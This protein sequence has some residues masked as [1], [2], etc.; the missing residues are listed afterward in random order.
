MKIKIR[1]AKTRRQILAARDLVRMVYKKCFGLDLNLLKGT[2]KQHFKKEVLIATCPLTN[3]ILGTLSFMYPN[4]GVFPCESFFGYDLADT[5]KDKENYI[6]IGR[7]ATNDESKK[8]LIVVISLFLGMAQFLEER[9]L[10]GWIAVIKDHIYDFFTRIELP[11]NAINQP[12]N[13]PEEDPMWLY[14]EDTKKLH[15]FDISSTESIATFK[16]V[17]QRYLDNGSIDINF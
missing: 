12:P 3:E 13:L 2:K 15:L 17:F 8:N 7:F 5:L 16:K 14:I 9:K 6:E 10:S 11:M 1:L 4:K